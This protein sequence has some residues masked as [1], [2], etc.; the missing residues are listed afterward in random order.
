ML[1]VFIALA[2][3]LVIAV[4]FFTIYPFVKKTG[5]K[6]NFVEKYG[7]S[8]YKLANHEDFYLINTLVFKGSDGNTFQIDHLLITEKYFFIIK[9]YYFDGKIEGKVDDS[10][11]IYYFGN[12]NKPKKA[13][14]DNPLFANRNRMSQLS[15]LTNIDKSI[16]AS[17]IL[18]NDD[19]IISNIVTN[20]ESEFI[21][22]RKD[23]KKFVKSMDSNENIGRLDQE[24]LTYTVHDL[25]RMNLKP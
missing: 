13:F 6:N 3:L 23:L 24:E 15:I 5:W 10:N 1:Y 16:M 22:K 11:W 8:V 2:I 9:D 12:P 19:C 17:I 20:N 25:A 4:L 7:K 18:V 21:V 14:V